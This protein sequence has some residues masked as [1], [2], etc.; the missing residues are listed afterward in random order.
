MFT[1][2]VQC[3]VY[4]W[5]NSRR[6]SHPPLISDLNTSCR[7]QNAIVQITELHQI[8]INPTPV[9][10]SSQHRN[11][12][13][14]II[15]RWHM[16]FGFADVDIYPPLNRTDGEVREIPWGCWIWWGILPKSDRFNYFCIHLVPWR[17]GAVEGFHM[18]IVLLSQSYYI[19]LI[20]QVN[21][22]KRT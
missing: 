4:H 15:L 1:G 10:I 11:A 6:D 7:Q 9:A 22:H 2:W 14:E 19:I 20:E 5:E 12:K 3:K 21:A 8:Y 13:M 16:C 18:S 17:Q